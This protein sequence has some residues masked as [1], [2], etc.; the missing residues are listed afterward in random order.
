MDP[1]RSLRIAMVLDAW[2]DAR[3]GAVISTR[4]FTD[5]LRARGHRVTIIAAGEPGQAGPDRVALREFY[6]P[7][8]AGV[9]RKMR[10]PFAW[11]DGK[12]LR[13]AIAEQDVVH[14][15]FPFWL[16]ASALSVARSLGVPAVSTFHVQAEH[17]LYNIGLR[18]P[19]LVRGLYRLFIRSIYDRSQLVICPSEFA[20]GE[21][22]TYGLRTPTA[23]LSNGVLPDYRPLPRQEWAH[24]TE[25]D[26]DKIVL[27]SVGRLAREKRHDLLI[28]AVARSR[29]QH[30]IQLVL[31]GDGPLKEKLI[32]Q[33]RALSNPPRFLYLKPHEII[34]WYNAAHLYV[35]AADVEVECM[36]VL[37]AMGCGLPCLI[38]CSP[39]SAARKFALGEEFLYQWDSRTDLTA[40]IDHWVERP[41]ELQQARE[42]Y[43]IA[44]EDYRIDKSLARLEEAYGHLAEQRAPHAARLLP[45]RAP[46]LA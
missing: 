8:A 45:A 30:R 33:G 24:L 42:R 15:H 13:E 39:K 12:L 31:I 23:V 27:L 11:P 2:D 4:R 17:L 32:A 10:V 14:V 29:H 5:L 3:T 38:A 7:F 35:H 18:S 6:P 34:P 46:D 43:R 28:E 37:E 41:D 40:R 22:R 26:G 20:E 36:A 19:A 25:Q 16:G 9:M 21:L 1:T 44:A